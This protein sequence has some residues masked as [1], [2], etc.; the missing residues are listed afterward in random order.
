MLPHLLLTRNRSMSDLS[1]THGRPVSRATTVPT[2][3]MTA[4]STETYAVTSSKMVFT[5]C[6]LGGVAYGLTFLM[7]TDL[8]SR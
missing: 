4:V 1:S 8:L 6:A 7:L 5:V 3:T 2:R